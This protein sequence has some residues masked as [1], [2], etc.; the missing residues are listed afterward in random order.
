MGDFFGVDPKKVPIILLHRSTLCQTTWPPHPP[1]PLPQGASG[2]GLRR[3]QREY[4]TPSVASR[5]SGLVRLF[6]PPPQKSLPFFSA[7]ALHNG[8]VLHNGS[9]VCTTERRGG[10]NEG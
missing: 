3:S 2:E 9:W 7:P 4:L 10:A 1:A 8:T 5:R 6:L